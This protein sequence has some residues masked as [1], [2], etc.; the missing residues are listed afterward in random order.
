[1]ACAAWLVTTHCTD[2]THV[3]F[4]VVPGPRLE[5][6]PLL[7]WAWGIYTSVHT[8]CAVCGGAFHR[9]P[10]VKAAARDTWR[11][12]YPLQSLLSS[13]L[14]VWPEGVGPLHV[15]TAGYLASACLRCPRPLPGD[16][17][18]GGLLTSGQ[19]PPKRQKKNQ[20]PK[21]VGS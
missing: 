19:S 12:G 15:A 8:A 20:N 1:M 3:A 5:S 18:Q 13:V 4:T 17:P 21:K 14:R 11:G 7:M 2:R 9:F 6:S 16:G 10:R